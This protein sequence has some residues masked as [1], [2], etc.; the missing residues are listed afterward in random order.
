MVLDETTD[1]RRAGS[2]ESSPMT[3]NDTGTTDLAQLENL[4]SMA[5]IGD[6]GQRMAVISSWANGKK[7]GT[8]GT[9]GGV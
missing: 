8:S 7:V 1:F 6:E 5:A 9:S 4:V 3:A 2:P